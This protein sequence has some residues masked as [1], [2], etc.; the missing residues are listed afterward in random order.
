MSTEAS[1]PKVII[2]GTSLI[3]RRHA[4]SLEQ[5]PITLAFPISWVRCWWCGKVEPYGSPEI[6]AVKRGRDIIYMHPKCAN[7]HQVDEWNK[8]PPLHGGD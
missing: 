2:P 8:E 6:Q 1:I 4:T 3:H 7:E 5:A